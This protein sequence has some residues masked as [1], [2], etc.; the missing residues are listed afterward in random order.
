MLTSHLSKILE[1]IIRAQLV[2]HMEA[3]G[4][5]DKS[6]H[7]SRRGRST[8]SQLLIQP[9]FILDELLK[10]NNIDLVYLDLS[11]AFDKCDLGILIKK[12]TKN[13][14]LRNTSQMD[15]KVYTWKETSSQSGIQY[16]L[17][18]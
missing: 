8:L 4:K 1:Q 11:K 9:D 12:T 14:D 5:M 6:Q 10:G 7:G 18:E 2:E 17:L 13:G 3:S 15:L 16:I